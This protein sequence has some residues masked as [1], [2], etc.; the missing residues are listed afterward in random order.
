MAM[1]LVP[2]KPLY[3]VVQMCAMLSKQLVTGLHF[4]SSDRCPI[5]EEFSNAESVDDSV[6]SL[7]ACA[8]CNWDTCLGTVL[9]V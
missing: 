3:F 6:N 2:S 8:D 9:L 4:V 5:D 7:T 1:G